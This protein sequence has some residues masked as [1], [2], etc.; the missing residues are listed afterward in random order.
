MIEA[1]R[2]GSIHSHF[3]ADTASDGITLRFLKGVA[4]ENGGV[5]QKGEDVVDPANGP[6]ITEL[7][8]MSLRV[9]PNV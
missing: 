8:M 3:H 5:P 4:L 6:V 2:V 1:F 9:G 7:S